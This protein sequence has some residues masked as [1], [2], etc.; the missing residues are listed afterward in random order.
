MYVCEHTGEEVG[1]G[2][3]SI[4]FFQLVFVPEMKVKTCCYFQLIFY[5][6]TVF[7]GLC[8]YSEPEPNG[9]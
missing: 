2:K 9:S 1:V 3:K 4:N 6:W 7:V 5:C 8:H